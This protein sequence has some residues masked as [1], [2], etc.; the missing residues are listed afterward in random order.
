MQKKLFQK[1][2]YMKKSSKK[3]FKIIFIFKLIQYNLK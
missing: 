2:N 1:K 3:F